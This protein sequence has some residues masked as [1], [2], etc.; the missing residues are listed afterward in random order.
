MP[1]YTL[2]SD[3][4]GQDEHQQRHQRRQ[5]LH[6]QR[7]RLCQHGLLGRS[8]H[9]QEGNMFGDTLV[10]LSRFDLVGLS[11]SMSFVGH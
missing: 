10:V 1:I 6:R 2:S 8:G 11:I 3:T 4:G 9:G 7:C 5:E